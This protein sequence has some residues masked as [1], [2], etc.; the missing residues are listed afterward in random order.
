MTVQTT[1]EHEGFQGNYHDG[2][3]RSL[4]LI[5][6]SGSDG[7]MR[8]AEATAKRFSEEGIPSL[9]VAYYKTPQTSRDLSEIPVEYI[10][11]AIHWLQGK[12]FSK[13]A[14][15]GISKGAEY[16]LVSAS[17]LPAISGVIALSCS[18]CVFGGLSAQ[19]KALPTSSWSWKGKPLPCLSMAGYSV[20][21][22]KILLQNRELR[23]LDLYKHLLDTGRNEENTIK[24]EH[25]Q[26]PILLQSGHEDSMWPAEEMGD[27]IVERLADKKFAHD[28]Q[29]V[30]FSPGSHLLS[31]MSSPM[32][33]LYRLERKNRDACNATRESAFANSLEFLR[34]L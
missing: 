26:G 19:R 10:E 3:S 24:V 21:I 4:A 6:V 16:A 31:P 15:H 28:Y 1:V 9:A 30:V 29:H 33:I 14:I 34:K 17:L 32:L 25:I 20:S 8:V 11:C 13:I 5:V 12:G 27:I 18:C 22:P 23:L 7:G 2:D